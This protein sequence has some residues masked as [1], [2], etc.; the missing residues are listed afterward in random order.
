MTGLLAI[1]NTAL[2]KE[3]ASGNF[4]VGSGDGLDG[5]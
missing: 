5:F 3:A 4:L 2:K 1:Q